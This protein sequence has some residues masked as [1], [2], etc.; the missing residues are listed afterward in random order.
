M[1]K[2]KTKQKH[3]ACCVIDDFQAQQHLLMNTKNKFYSF[4]LLFSQLKLHVYF[5]KLQFLR[6][7]HNFCCT[8]SHGVTE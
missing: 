3:P 2:R 8:S 5:W 1:T 4:Y 7:F 6:K